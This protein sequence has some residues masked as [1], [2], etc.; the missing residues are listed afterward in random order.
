MNID[1]RLILRSGVFG[2]LFFSSPEEEP[3][4]KERGRPPRRCQGR[5]R[6]ERSERE[7]GSQ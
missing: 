7:G 4:W 3:R 2:R 5:P 1:E 6:E